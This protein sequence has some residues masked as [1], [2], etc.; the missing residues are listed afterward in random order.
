M[1]TGANV[2]SHF[3]NHGSKYAAAI[4][5][6]RE[7]HYAAKSLKRSRMMSDSGESK[8]SLNQQF[9][10]RVTYVNRRESRR[11][12][13]RRQRD[14]RNFRRQ[15]VANCKPQRFIKFNNTQII[16][17]VNEQSMVFLPPMYSLYGSSGTQDHIFKIANDM[18][19]NIAGVTVNIPP[20]RV[21]EK[22]LY[23][24]S[25]RYT[26]EIVNNEAALPVYL[27]LY[28]YYLTD[29][30]QY[31]VMNTLLATQRKWNL[32][33]T[34]AVS[35]TT[36]NI[37]PF[38]L[39]EIVQKVHITKKTEFLLTAGSTQE[40]EMN[41]TQN[42]TFDTMKLAALSAANVNCGVSGWTKGIIAVAI[43][44]ANTTNNAVALTSGVTLMG[45]YR[46]SVKEIVDEV[47]LPS[48]TQT[49]S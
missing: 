48:T 22:H 8:V 15:A 45:T 28:E 36:I 26:L 13:R 33:A 47:M 19:L 6:A 27:T 5:T 16:T 7:I 14:K 24:E 9:P 1:V 17:N 38:D 10:S 4:R 11:H 41:D 31:A 18:L 34:S 46:Y 40:Y 37:T 3:A 2:V 25:C 42:K 35:P 23:F 12:K 44:P 29:D 49:F 30:V 39:T 43:G 20:E 21:N 32:G